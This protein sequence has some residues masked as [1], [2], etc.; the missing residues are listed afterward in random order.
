MATALLKFDL[1]NQ[2]DLQ[3]F[4]RMNQSL[5]MA[6]CLWE[7]LYNSK[8]KVI[9]QL[10]EIDADERLYEVVDELFKSFWI[11][12]EERGVKIDNLIS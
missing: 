5:D 7:I 8:K 4:M 11:I 9:R 2:D 1:N 10:D 3:E 12:C 6:L